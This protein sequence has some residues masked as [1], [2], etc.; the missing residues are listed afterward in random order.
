MIRSLLELNIYQ[1]FRY[2]PLIFIILFILLPIYIIANLIH[3]NKRKS[4]IKITT[5]QIIIFFIIT[6]IYFILR[7]TQAG[8]CLIPTQI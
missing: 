7:N 1:A 4:F 3:Y 6:V 8:I 5:P 2:N